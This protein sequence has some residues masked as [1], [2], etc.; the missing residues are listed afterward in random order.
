MDLSIIIVNYNVRKYLLRCLGSLFNA[1]EGITFEVI[2]IDNASSDGSVEALRKNSPQVKLIANPDNAGFA[3]AN[4]QGIRLAR[5]RNILLLN[6]DTEIVDDSLE[7][8]ARFLDQNEKAGICGPILMNADGSIQNM[9]YKFPAVSSFFNSRLIRAEAADRPYEAD[10]IQGA[11]LMVKRGLLEEVGDLDEKYF[12]YG[13]E[14]D[15]CFRAKAAGWK[16]LVLPDCGIIHHS[17]K[18]TRDCESFAF[19]EYHRSQAYFLKKYYPKWF[20]VLAGYSMFL[21]ILK[22]KIALSLFRGH[23]WRG[24]SEV[25]GSVLKWYKNER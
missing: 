5:G 8:M 19:V 11:C 1:T 10:W 17:S 20:R 2:I 9:G 16:V 7:R 13:E 15:L 6:P 24:K 18:S 23:N 4:N 25:F 3:K 21:N 14:K 12:L 22:S